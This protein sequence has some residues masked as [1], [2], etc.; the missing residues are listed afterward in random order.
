MPGD[1]CSM[2]RG[3]VLDISAFADRMPYSIDRLIL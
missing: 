1:R 2:G 3:R